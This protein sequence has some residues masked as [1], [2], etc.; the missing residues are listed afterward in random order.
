MSADLD[1]VGN[2][3]EGNTFAPQPSV[4]KSATLAVNHLRAVVRWQRIE[5]GGREYISASGSLVA[6]HAVEQQIE[7]DVVARADER[8]F[9]C[10]SLQNRLAGLGEENVSGQIGERDVGANLPRF[11][12]QRIS[13]RTEA[14]AASRWRCL[15]FPRLPPPPPIAASRGLQGHESIAERSHHEQRPL[16]FQSI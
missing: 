14:E 13:K 15:G 7:S 4:A 16:R 1:F 11:I 9:S 5:Y 3:F 6:E 2:L 8:R 10:R 12:K